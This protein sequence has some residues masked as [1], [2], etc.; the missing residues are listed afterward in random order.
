MFETVIESF[1]ESTPAE[2]D[3]VIAD[4][5][6]AIREAEGR[7]AD[8]LAKASAHPVAG[9]RFGEFAAQLLDHAEQLELGD[10]ETVMSH[11][12]QMAD[13]DGSFDDQRFREEQRHA[14]VAVSN[15]S[16]ELHASGGSPLVAAE[17][18]AVFLLAVQAEFE[19]DC[20]QRRREHG[21][22]ALAAPL[23]RTAQ[24]RKFD[25]LH[26]I[27]MASV[28]V[29]A[30]GIAPAPLVNILIDHVTAGD[31]LHRHGMVPSP[32][33]FGTGDAD[34][35]AKRA[36]LLG[37]ECS[38]N[39][40][41]VHPDIP[42]R[43]CD[44]DH[45]AEWG[46]DE[47]RTDQ[48]NAMPACG[49]HDRWKHRHRIRTRRAT[50]GRIHLVRPDGSTISPVGA[51]EPEWAEPAPTGTPPDQSVDQTPPETKP[52]DDRSAA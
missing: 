21:D 48:A 47:G 42:A 25:A 28:S 35:E 15:G 37:R 11:F 10:F 13:P 26:A 4:A 34:V 9:E 50:N 8:L 3:A 32:D 27:F 46:A 12:V 22:G 20:E 6:L 39:R 29:E 1:V 45:R 23:P 30:G 17:I 43:A 19:K 33:I 31:V 7:L 51:R 14:S 41:P 18:E 49:V 52:P 24:Q 36:D 38:I 16:L 44:I 40:T 5:E 2:L